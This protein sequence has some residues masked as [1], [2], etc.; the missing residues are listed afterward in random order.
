MICRLQEIEISN[1][2]PFQNCKLGREKYGKIFS[3]PFFCHER[4]KLKNP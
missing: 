4:M 2:R 1:E 3:V